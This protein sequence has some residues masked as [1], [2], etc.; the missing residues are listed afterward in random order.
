MTL[1]YLLL[2]ALAAAVAAAAWVRTPDDDRPR[3]YPREP[4]RWGGITGKPA[5]LRHGVGTVLF[6]AVAA[7]GLGVGGALGSLLVPTQPGLA[8]ALG[9][10][11]G[12][13]LALWTARLMLRAGP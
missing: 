12:A 11:A 6:W 1:S 5:S 10:L 3:I 2:A 9:A 8:L 13:A 4:E 7:F